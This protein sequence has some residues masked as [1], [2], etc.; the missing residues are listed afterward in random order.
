[1]LRRTV[2]ENQQLFIN[3]KEVVGIQDINFNYNLPIDQVR[4]LGM[5]SVVFANNGPVLAEMNINKLMIDLDDFIQLTGDNT[6]SGHLQYKDK[7]FAFNSGILDNYNISCSVNEL[8]ALTARFSILGD[9]GSGI[10]KNDNIYPKNS[11]KILNYSDI[12]VSLNDFQFNRLQNFNMTVENPRNIL[13]KLG[14]SYPEQI[15]SNSPVE[16]NL[17]F[18]I[19]VDEYQIKNI[20]NL[21]CNYDVNSLN[22]IFKEFKNPFGASVLTHSFDEIL[23]LGESYNS[24][25]NGSVDLTLNYKAFK[26]PNLIIS[27]KEI[28]PPEDTINRINTISF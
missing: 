26:R 28:L 17:S 14:S 10:Q 24:N 21:I 12:E 27:Q 3:S 25:I 5:E 6:F 11:Y 19:K 23:F 8:V 20:R 18:S 4:Y 13:Y 9:F 16:V 2:K 22:I 1:M 15:I 7:Y